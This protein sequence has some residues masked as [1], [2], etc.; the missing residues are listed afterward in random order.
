MNRRTKICLWVIV[1]G[2]A[3][4][5]LYVIGYVSLY[6]EA[7]NGRIVIE[8]GQRY[9]FLQSGRE[10]SR[11]AF[12]YSGVHSI[13]IWPTVMA[14]MLAMLTLAKDRITASM[15]SAVTRGRVL[16]T[17]FAVVMVLISV[18]L[19][20]EFVHAFVHRFEKPQIRAPESK[21]AGSAGLVSLQRAYRDGEAPRQ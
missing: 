13:S 17:L 9:Y 19:T 7:I 3:N 2:L 5:L 15:Q 12:I 6:G 4:F 8:A 21:P 18:L 1:I 10:V 14:V 11:A 16:I 20:Y